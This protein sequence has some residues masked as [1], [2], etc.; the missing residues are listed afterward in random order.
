[1]GFKDQR[2]KV[3]GGISVQPAPDG[4]TDLVEFEQIPE[5]LDAIEK[6]IFKLQEKIQKSFW[7]IGKRLIIIQEK[8][9]D[10]IKYTDFLEYVEKEF[11]IKNRTA[12]NLIFLAKNFTFGQALAHGSKLYILSRLQNPEQKNECLKWMDESNRTFREVEDWVKEK[13]ENQIPEQE[14]IEHQHNGFFWKT[15]NLS[16]NLKKLNCKINSF[17]HDDINSKIIDI[18]KDYSLKTIENKGDK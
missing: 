15:N 3:D 5:S 12:K 14:I 11:G 16:I 7:F 13:I 1:M 6:E 10:K 17:Y 4:F 8:Y 2:K 9:I 18:L